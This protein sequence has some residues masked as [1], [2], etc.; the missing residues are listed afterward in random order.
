MKI[1]EISKKVDGIP[2]MTPTQA[3]VMTSFVIE[4][5]IQNILELGFRHGVSTCYM[6]GALDELG[7]GSVTTIDLLPA[8]NAKPNIESLLADFGLQKFVTVYYE[9]TSYTWRLMKML[10]ESSEP[11]FDFCYLDGAH[12]WFVDGFA[13]FLIDRLLFPGGW[14]VFDDLDWTYAVSPTLKETEK[15]KSMPQEEKE[16]AQVRKIY[17]LLVKSH[18]S[19]GDFTIKDGWA[20]A[21]KLSSNSGVLKTQEVKKEIIY[22]KEYVGIGA[23]VLKIAKAI[24][25]R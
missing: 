14:I 25:R 12:S 8:R 7:R 18:P 21:R 5:Q 13:F 22:Q 17:E 23:V 4:N 11:R 24:A 9:P 6:A 15:V 16:T 20:Y 2:N 10:E 3:K 19:Y 1:D